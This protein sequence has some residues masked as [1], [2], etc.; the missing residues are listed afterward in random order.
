MTAT[1]LVLW[2]S[3]LLLLEGR[4]PGLNQSILNTACDFSGKHRPGI[5]RSRN[6]FLPSLQHFVKFLP[7]LGINKRIGVH[8]GLVEIAP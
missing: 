6:R 5:Q 2:S 8:E 4:S 7:S 1:K 3:L